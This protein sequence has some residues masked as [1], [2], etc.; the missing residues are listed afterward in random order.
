MT[1]TFFRLG[2]M[3]GSFEKGDEGGCTLWTRLELTSSNRY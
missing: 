2:V 3:Q 1:K